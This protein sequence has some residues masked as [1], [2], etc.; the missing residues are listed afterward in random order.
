MTTRSAFSSDTLTV[1]RLESGPVS[2]ATIAS[3]TGRGVWVPP[4]PS[5]NA[6]PWSSEGKWERRAVTSKTM[7]PVCYAARASAH[8]WSMTVGRWCPHSITAPVSSVTLAEQS[9]YSIQTETFS[10]PDR[11]SSA[12]AQK[13]TVNGDSLPS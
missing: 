11:R 4:G 7:P 9:P 13:S 8:S 2:V 6:R 12:S 5:K 10:M 3:P 1:P